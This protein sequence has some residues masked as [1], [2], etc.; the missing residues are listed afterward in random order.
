MILLR[1]SFVM[2]ALAGLLAGCAPAAPM[3]DT[4]VVEP[5][6]M[7]P[8]ALPPTAL[9]TERPA[10]TEN[11]S[12]GCVA[13]G[14]YDAELDYFPQKSEIKLTEGFM[15]EYHKHYKLV[16]VNMPYPGAQEPAVYVLVQCGTPAP[17]GFEEAQV[18]EV[19]V[20][21]VVSMSTSYLPSL[22]ALGVLDR[23]VG[24]DDATYVSNPTVQQMAAE[25]KLTNLGYGSGVNVEAALAL[26]PDLIL[27]YG[28]G[29]PDYDAHPV[30]VEAGLKSVLNAEWLETSPLGR[31]EW[32][33]FIALFFNREA[34]A[35]EAFNKTAEAYNELAT[36]AGQAEEKPSVFTA[37]DYQGT[38]YVPGGNSFAA[39]LLRDAGAEYLWAD[40]E[41]TGSLP[42]AFESVFE[43]AGEADVWVNIGYFFSLDELLAADERYAEFA[44]FQNGAVWNNDARMGA[45]GGNDYYESAV[46]H[47][48]VVLA[49]LVSIFHPELMAGYERVYYRQVK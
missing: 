25:D 31:A 6:V 20:E 21:S 44:A 29:S 11:L 42:L 16:T 32:M 10:S 27:T 9:P 39:A 3:A 8:S 41:S 45:T 36:L 34:I 46:I 30:L 40:D 47:P 43:T 7:E 1:K 22:E 17:T 15:V 13:P 2:I 23:L 18:I 49:D 19:P 12:D 4:A 14:E 24:L 33:K 5:A 38:W 37:S 48:D 35:E 28:S 26:D